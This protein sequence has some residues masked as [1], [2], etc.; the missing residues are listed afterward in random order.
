MTRR[1]LGIAATAAL[2]LTMS[3][4]A[5]TSPISSQLD[6]APSDGARVVLSPDNSD[7]RVEN[8]MILTAAEGEPA[9]VFGIIANDTGE[10][11]TVTVAIEGESAEVDV[12]ARG[13]TDLSA[14]LSPYEGLNLIPGATAEAAFTYRGTVTHSIPILDGTLAPYDQYLP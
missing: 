10:D 12:P 9:Q 6:Y 2:A 13:F 8:V 5:F 7:V 1:A 4:C 14:E 11:A 3:G